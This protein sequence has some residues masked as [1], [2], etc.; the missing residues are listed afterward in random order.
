[1]DGPAVSLTNSTTLHPSFTAPPVPGTTDLTLRLTVS[2]TQLTGQADVVVT[3]KNGPPLC[4]LARAVPGLLWPPAHTMPSVSIVGV[5]DPDDDTVAIRVTGVTQDE[6]VNGLGDGDISPDA[7]IL[8][9][10]KV[11]LRAERSGVGN[12]RVYEVHFTAG[13]GQGAMC[14]GSVRVGVPHSM[15]PGLPLIDD[16]QLYNS[17]QP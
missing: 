2:D 5:T 3:V 6:P 15:K 7:V 16:G 1:M 4:N 8:E 12:G 10:N 14:M 9:D 11:L 17:T 13:D